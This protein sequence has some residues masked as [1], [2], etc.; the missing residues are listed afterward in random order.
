MRSRGIYILT[1]FFILS[2]FAFG[3]MAYAAE[4]IPLSPS[5]PML[6]RG[7]EVGTQGGLVR[8]LN[9]LVFACVAIAAVLAVVMVAVG[10]FKYMTTDS[11][12][13]MGSAKEQITNAIVGLLIVLAAVLILRT[14]NA[15]LVSMK[16]FQVKETPEPPQ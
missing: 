13:A 10:G 16:I 11:M 7:I 5:F 15:D 12:F 1:N 3:S 14:I 9:M 2:F 6:G 4:F 8:F